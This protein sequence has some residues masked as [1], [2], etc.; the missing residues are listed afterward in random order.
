MP[1]KSIKKA[2]N[3]KSALK[4]YEGSKADMKADK[5]GAKKLVKKKK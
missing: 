3:L 1:K 2:T 5:A 4:K